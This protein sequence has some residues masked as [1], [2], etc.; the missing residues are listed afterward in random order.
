MVGN[1][2]EGD[3]THLLTALEGVLCHA[4]VAVSYSSC[5]CVAS[6]LQVL[7]IVL[8]ADSCSCSHCL[9]WTAHSH[10]LDV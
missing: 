6:T 1:G 8:P 2:G 9:R 5:F 3:A 4:C 10:F 7:P